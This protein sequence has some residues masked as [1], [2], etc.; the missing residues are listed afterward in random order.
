MISKKISYLLF[1]IMMSLQ[2]QEKKHVP[3]IVK[4]NS[5]PNILVIISDQHS[6]RVMTQKGY[7]HVT[8]PGIDKL[9]K[10]GVTFTRGYCTYPVCKSSRAS[11]ITGVM[12]SKSNTHLQKHTSIGTKLKDNGYNT[13]YF[14]KWHVANTKIKDNPEWH[15][16]ET[17]KREY[18]DS[19]TTELS[20]NFIKDKH[21]KPFF[22]ITSLLNPHDCCELARNI[23]GLEDKYHDGA[24]DENKQI[25]SCP[26]LPTNFEIPDKEAEGFYTRRNPDKKDRVNY[27]KHPVKFWKKMQWRQYMYG[28]D[29]LVEKMDNHILKIINTLEQQGLLDNTIV[30]YTSDHGDGHS[31]HKW[32]QKMNFYEE[33]INIPFVVSWKGVTKK[34]V[35]DSKTLV[36]NGLDLYPTIC[37]LAGIEPESFLKGQN[38]IPEIL[39]N[40]EKSKIKRNYVV[41][42]LTQKENNKPNKRVFRGRMVVTAQYKY[43]IFN[44]GENPEQFFDLKNDPD[45]LNSLINSPKHQK[46]IKEHRDMLN[47]WINMTNDSFIVRNNL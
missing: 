45:E 33:S 8:T 21:Q 42:E 30:F 7:Q 31:S 25:D 26:P 14:G 9:A 44:G 23:S 38:L 3:K 47:E 40:V 29:R 17:Y 34:G 2:C 24:V 4:K 37:K 28:Y 16:F 39:K 19:K 10:E 15:G 6:G 36:S 35:I 5:T 18:N 32:N 13:A 20:I 1:L 11:L 43:F 41:S 22:L 12:P 46:E 27:R